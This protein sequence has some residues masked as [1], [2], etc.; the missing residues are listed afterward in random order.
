MRIRFDALSE[1]LASSDA[2][3]DREYFKKISKEHADLAPLAEAAQEYIRVFLQMKDDFAAA[4]EEEDREI[5]HQRRNNTELCK[6][7]SSMF[8]YELS[9]EEINAGGEK[10]Q[11]DPYR[12]TPGIEEHRKEYKDQIAVI[13]FFECGVVEKQIQR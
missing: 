3:S 12:L 4:E 7:G 9:V 1:K 8:F 13:C 6:G 11:Y 10:Q 2:L 5:Q